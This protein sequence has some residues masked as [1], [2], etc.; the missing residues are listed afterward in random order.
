MAIE[1]FY[2]E[3][4]GVHTAQEVDAYG[5]NVTTEGAPFVFMG[6]IGKPS[7]RQAIIME[8]RG[9][10]ID[11][12]L[13][14]PVDAGIMPF[15]VLTDDTGERYQVVSQPRDVARRGHHVE[16]DLLRIAGGGANA[17]SSR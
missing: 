2:H 6:Y 4:T 7:S 13:Y 11:G 1:N 16:A 3:I 10:A 14:A 15:D 8:Q 5:D 17:D 9:I 12:R